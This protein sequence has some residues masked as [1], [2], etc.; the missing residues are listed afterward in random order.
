MTRRRYNPL[1]SLEDKEDDLSLDEPLKVAPKRKQAERRSLWKITTQD[2]KI[3]YEGKMYAIVVHL[4]Y[5][6][7]FDDRVRLRLFRSI[8]SGFEEAGFTRCRFTIDETEKNAKAVDDFYQLI[9]ESLAKLEKSAKEIPLE[10]ERRFLVYLKNLPFDFNKYP[11][12]TI[13]QGYLKKRGGRIRRES[14][15]GKNTYTKTIKSGKGV[16]LKELE[17]E[18]SKEEYFSLW[19]NIGH[20]LKKERYFI[21]WEGTEIQ[22]NIFLLDL[23]GYI[24][25]EVEFDSH[26]A[27]VNFAPPSWFGKEVT[28]DSRHDNYSLA[29]N[30]KPF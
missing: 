9:L 25:I 13:V 16:S 17:N 21:P 27:A 2:G 10:H 28:D 1:D 29:K 30:G 8:S 11:M 24:Q 5:R 22:L 12:S 19:G 7:L 14:Q 23:Q 3:V 15:N 18:I 26:E 6:K 4:A 20:Y